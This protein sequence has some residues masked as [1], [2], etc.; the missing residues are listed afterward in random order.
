MFIKISWF[1]YCWMVFREMISWLNNEDDV[2][3]NVGE[4]YDNCEWEL[5]LLELLLLIILLASYFLTV[6][7]KL[8]ILPSN[9]FLT[10]LKYSLYNIFSLCPQHGLAYQQY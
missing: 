7:Y 2:E 3:D 6:L 1:S 4:C 9:S 10:I 8:L 5:L